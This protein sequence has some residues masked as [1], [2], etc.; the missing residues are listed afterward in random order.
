[1][2]DE[3]W[4]LTHSVPERWIEQRAAAIEAG[5]IRRRPKRSRGIAV[6]A[7]AATLAVVVAFIPSLLNE[8]TGGLAVPDSAAATLL[9][10]GATAADRQWHP[11]RAREYHYVHTQS[12]GPTVPE[13]VGQPEQWPL[14]AETEGWTS[15]TGAA[16][17]L[18]VTYGLVGPTQC[19]TTPT[20]NQI[21]LNGTVVPVRDQCSARFV[22]AN[23]WDASGRVVLPASAVVADGRVHR[24]P[25]PFRQS[26][27]LP[28]KPVE[29]WMQEQWGVTLAEID[30]LP[31]AGAGVD[32]AVEDLLNRASKR[33]QFA[34]SGGAPTWDLPREL[35]MRR[36]RLETALQMLGA[37]P[38]PP[39][40]QRSLYRILAKEP[41]AQLGPAEHDRTGRE[42]RSIIFHQSFRRYFPEHTYT[43]SELAA[44]AV[45]DGAEPFTA[46]SAGPF[47]MPSHT[48]A[49]S[50]T[51]TI[52]ISP[53][54][55]SLLQTTRTGSDST[56]FRSPG[57]ALR[58]PVIGADVD[59]HGRRA[60][61]MVTA[62]GLQSRTRQ[63][64]VYLTS[65]RV[66]DQRPH[67]DLCS[68]YYRAC[69][70]FTSARHDPGE[71]S[72]Q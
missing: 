22:T 67:Q 30:A 26:W 58:V 7:A 61:S 59:R 13:D 71:S 10:A 23:S 64:M 55:G 72:L 2:L 40:A 47:V 51:V 54:D 9:A 17:A 19:V 1:M 16:R 33:S 69:E 12:Y 14:L 3:R 21:T 43:G 35:V 31:T 34:R 15:A 57:R 4:E 32:S 8:H 53:D 36:A 29:E 62:N 5:G 38:L 66:T 18:N 46:A 60:I 41:N 63:Q 11:L 28:H 27:N 65:E 20:V 39:Q 24:V 52:L 48:V 6:V 37:A 49:T 44:K 42:G 45:A 56:T 50:W 70:L 68:R 25:A